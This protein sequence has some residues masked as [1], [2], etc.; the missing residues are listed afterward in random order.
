MEGSA[1][2]CSFSC[3]A[4]FESFF[5]FLSYVSVFMFLELF[6]MF[7]V[8]FELFNMFIVEFEK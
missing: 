1:A 3:S 6:D 7:I 4:I 5:R 2:A 8:K